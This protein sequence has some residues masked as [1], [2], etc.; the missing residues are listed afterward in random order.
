MV[1]GQRQ[2]RRNIPLI[3]IIAIIFLLLVSIG[4][5][6]TFY[7]NWLWFM[8]VGFV[9]VFWTEIVTKWLFGLAFGAAFFVFVYLNIWLAR[10]FAPVYPP[11]QLLEG[12]TPFRGPRGPEMSVEELV[13]SIRAAIDP[14]VRWLLLGVAIL[15]AIGY[16]AATSENWLAY[17]RFANQV[18]FGEADP[19]YGRDIG[20]YFFTFPLYQWLYGWLFSGLVVTTI[21]TALVHVYDGAIRFTRGVER[22]APHVKAHLSVLLGLIALVQAWG[23]NLDIYNLLY[24]PRG[25]AIGASYT[26]VNA[27]LPALRLLVI[28]SIITAGLLIVNIQ[29]RGW[30][31]P[32]VALALW[33]A[34]IVLAGSVYPGIVQAYRVAPNEL[35]SE[36][37]YIR[38]NIAATL[39][40]YGLDK[41]NRRPFLP[42]G[43]LSQDQLQ[44]NQGTINNVRLWDPDT[45][46]TTYS[47]L[48]QLRLYYTFN[49]V[50]VDRYQISGQPRQVMV[51]VRELD[52]DLLPE[53]GKTWVNQHVIYTHG[54]GAVVSPVNRVT[55]DGLPDFL[56]R[57]VPPESTVESLR[58][59]QPRI[60]YGE[61]PDNYVV[62]GA[63]RNEFDY[64]RG[65]TNVYTNYTGRGGVTVSNPLRKLAFAL[66]FSSVELFLSPYVTNDSKILFRRNIRER[67]S[68][69][70]PFLGY[71]RDPYA[72]IVNG[73]IVFIQ[74]AYT[75]SDKYPYSEMTD[76]VGNYIRNSV[77]VVVDAYDGTVRFYIVD[78]RDPVIRTYARVFPRLFL[79]SERVP[80]ELRAHFRYPEDLFLIQSDTFRTYHMTNPDV[81]YNKEDLWAIPRFSS[82]EQAELMEP[83]YVLMKVPEGP[84]EEQFILFVPFTPNERNNMISWMA[85]P[86]DPANYGQL[87]AF[88]FPKQRLTFGPAQIDA[89][90]NQDPQI[91]QQIT[92]WDQAGSDVLRG[93]LLVIPIENALLY[94]Q[95]LYLRAA[96]ESALP[97]LERVIVAFGEDVVMQPTFADALASIFGEAPEVARPA[98]GVPAPRPPA[99]NVQELV[100]Q[101]NRHF[102]AAEEAARRGDWATYGREISALRQTL[103]RLSRESG[104]A[105]QGQ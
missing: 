39:Q 57:D 45:L 96:R 68:E 62:V 37:P 79:P 21:V 4:T 92:L 28:I 6:V 17:L 67:I 59:R 100:Q 3:V 58:I 50:D 32:I 53:R 103:G 46:K 93:N 78:P 30:R 48:Q 64:P 85:A 66:R 1:N 52:V 24:S 12:T 7:T 70:A 36:R 38:L 49:D 41:V 101:A 72:A 22:F 47:Q 76:G 91:S 51:S 16:G 83:Y 40:A 11:V 35:Q 43:Q 31:L 99:E 55:G 71:D 81:F 25:A 9:S 102:N 13:Q 82:G 86:S 42:A 77:K 90:I 26:D 10:R 74:D 104:A 69:I 19:L 94:V 5:A 87:L 75:M 34:A 84:A 98:P 56:V 15:L 54:F 2:A 80:A 44:E 14:F 23:Y 60:Y 88:E 33:G 61:R 8:E 18:P 65:E 73:R 27:Q 105:Q 89:R 97:Q 20:F 95:P 29:F 63:G